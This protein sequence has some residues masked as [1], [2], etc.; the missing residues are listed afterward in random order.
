M[1]SSSLLFP[2]HPTPW[3]GQFRYRAIGTIGE[4]KWAWEEEKEKEKGGA[5]GPGTGDEGRRLGVIEASVWMVA[6]DYYQ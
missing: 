2:F 4:W 5:G 3:P 1:L 6:T